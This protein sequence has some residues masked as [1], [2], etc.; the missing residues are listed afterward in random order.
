MLK[1]N[2]K[3]GITLLEAMITIVVIMIGILSLTKI[4]PIA[5]QIDKTSE[6]STVAANLAQSGLEDL[7]STGYNNLSVGTIEAKHRLASDPSDKLYQYQR[8]ILVEYVDGN[9]ETSIAETDLKKMTVNIYWYNQALKIEKTTQ[10]IS[11][12]SKK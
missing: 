12:I 3:K 11:L 2:N 1:L 8:E 6:Q 10:L 4:F 9:L 7:F 5:F